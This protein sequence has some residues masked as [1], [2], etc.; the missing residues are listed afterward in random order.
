MQW[1]WW[2]LAATSSAIRASDFRFCHGKRYNE[3]S[4]AGA[5]KRVKPLTNNMLTLFKSTLRKAKSRK[6]EK[7][8]LTRK[9]R[10]KPTSLG[11]LL[12]LAI[13]GAILTVPASL[14]Q[15][16]PLQRSG[17]SHAQEGSPSSAKETT[18]TSKSSTT[19]VKPPTSGAIKTP[20]IDAALVDADRLTG[21]RYRPL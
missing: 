8:K 18:H 9:S 6:N 12:V 10:I 7:R 14:S 17:D 3:S 21:R 20:T 13:I 16:S 1:P 2:L 11:V 5:R 4:A 15:T 19:K